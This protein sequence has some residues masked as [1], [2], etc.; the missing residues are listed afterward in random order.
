MCGIFGFISQKTFDFEDVAKLVSNSIKHRGPD[1]HHHYYDKKNN[2]LIGHRRLSIID[3]SSNADQP[4]TYNNISISFNGE[5]YN[6][7]EL[8][9]ELLGE[10]VLFDTESDTEVLIK[11]YDK[12]G[13]DGF[14]KLNGMFA[15]AFYDKNINKLIL[16]RD[17]IGEKPLLYFNSNRTFFWP[18]I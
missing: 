3:L 13:V 14:S 7:K 10:G 8:K 16:L 9:D 6:Y 11:V 17:R 2:A 1:S 15:V 18:D 12:W 5:I 4:Y